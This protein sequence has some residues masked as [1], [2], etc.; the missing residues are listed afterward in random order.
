MGLPKLAIRPA[1]AWGSP[2]APG[3]NQAVPYFQE[4]W[5]LDRDYVESNEETADA[6]YDRGAS[7]TVNATLRRYA[8]SVAGPVYYPTMHPVLLTV[9]GAYTETVLSVARTQRIYGDQ[10][11]QT[12]ITSSGST[13]A[14]NPF[15]TV[16]V[17]RRHAIWA[18]DSAI[19]KG[20]R[21]NYQ[22]GKQVG[23][24]LDLLGHDLDVASAY[25]PSSWTFG[26]GLAAL[27]LPAV[28]R[29]ATAE[30]LVAP[31]DAG[32]PLG[33]GHKKNLQALDLQLAYQLAG[34]ENVEGY[35]SDRAGKPSWVGTTVTGTFKLPRYDV[36]WLTW[37][38]NHTRLMATLTLTGPEK[39]V[40]EPYLFKLWLPR[41]YVTVDLVPTG[42]DLARP[43]V[44]FRGQ[45]S[46]DIPAGFTAAPNGRSQLIIETHN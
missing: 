4:G 16:G 34:G 26:G 12:L 7:K 27:L 44:S 11:W 9:F 28:F 20:F 18:V 25:V 37:A 8:S 13:S 6:V 1:T 33:A 41:L 17:D 10:W 14:V 46:S 15:H 43:T 19:T 22:A 36:D 21:L 23:W 2:L 3:A 5:K 24:Q 42:L 35:E 39:A 38:A 29:P 32:T 45:V 31:F 30:F 40:G